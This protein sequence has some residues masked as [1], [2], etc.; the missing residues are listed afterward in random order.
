M[1]YKVQLVLACTIIF[2]VLRTI[3]RCKKHRLQ[4]EDLQVLPHD[5]V[6]LC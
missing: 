4:L 1:C 3:Q 6:L 2:W 5:V